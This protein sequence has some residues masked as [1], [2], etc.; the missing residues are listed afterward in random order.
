MTRDLALLASSPPGVVWHEAAAPPA[1]L[2]AR[3]AAAGLALHR[4]DLSGAHG[5]RALLAALGKALRF[6]AWYGQNWD[7]LADCL[8]DLSWLEPGPLLVSLEQAGPLAAQAPGDLATALEVLGE[9]AAG[10]R[11][12]GRP[13]LFLWQ[14]PARPAGVPPLA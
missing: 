1:D 5:K 10:W 4:V 8:R 13:V 14:G 3:A 11:D 12:R 7:G 9:A 2:A 6:P